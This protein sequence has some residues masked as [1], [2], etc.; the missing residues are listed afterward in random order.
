M[1]R[2]KK[3]KVENK[4]ESIMENEIVENIPADLIEEAKELTQY[5]VRGLRQ[6]K[7]KQKFPGNKQ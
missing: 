3:I 2:P 5:Q 4:V 7:D 6:L 1:G